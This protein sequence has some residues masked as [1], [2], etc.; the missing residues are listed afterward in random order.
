MNRKIIIPIIAV[1]CLAVG[2]TAGFIAGKNSGKVVFESEPYHMEA[3]D[4]SIGVSEEG[5][6]GFEV[7]DE[8][9]P[10]KSTATPNLPEKTTDSKKT[11]NNSENAYPGY[12]GNSQQQ[13]QE[14]NIGVDQETESGSV[15][16]E[17]VNV[18]GAD[19][20]AP[21]ALKSV[22]YNDYMQM[23]PDERG[24]LA[25]QFPSTDQFY[26]WV[27][28]IKN[29]SVAADAERTYS[30]SVNIDETFGNN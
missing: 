12:N 16:D 11:S 17:P 28:A 20:N 25:S 30:G 29:E 15:S 26:D 4:F 24:N 9:M 3:A 22:T 8:I 6:A 10:P 19:N 7:E 18:K 13:S 2:L 21:G 1:G 5:N 23:T 27:D 14:S